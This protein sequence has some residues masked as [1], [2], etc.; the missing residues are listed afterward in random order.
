MQTR[1]KIA[2]ILCTM[3]TLCLA[4]IPTAQA[5]TPSAAPS[6]VQRILGF[7]GDLLRPAVF[8][9]VRAE[10]ELS[11]R[12]E[13]ADPSIGEAAHGTPAAGIGQ[14]GWMP[15]YSFERLLEETR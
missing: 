9:V 10:A 8:D 2:V 14:A 11:V 5:F 6:I 15:F 7:V 4:S 12:V 13:A 1:T 3:V